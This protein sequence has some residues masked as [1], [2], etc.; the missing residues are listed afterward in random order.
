MLD[1]SSPRARPFALILLLALLA[2]TSLGALATSDGSAKARPPVDTYAG[3]ARVEFPSSG[4]G[5][6]D[7][8]GVVDVTLRGSFIRA[9]RFG[10]FCGCGAG[11]FVLDTTSN[12]NAM[13]PFANY[14][15]ATLSLPDSLFGSI[16]GP[17]GAGVERPFAANTRL[18][19]T[20]SN[21][22]EKATIVVVGTYG[23]KAF[24]ITFS[25]DRIVI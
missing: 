9:I 12:W 20:L 6:Y 24:R 19:M 21:N 2:V 15:Y 3:T 18:R 10:S 1:R 13:S 8:L 5:P 25:G 23:G 17:P 4:E 22:G 16:V 14:L 7:H 11:A